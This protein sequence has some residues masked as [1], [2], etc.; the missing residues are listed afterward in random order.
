[1][2]KRNICFSAAHPLVAAVN[3]SLIDTDT[4]SKY[5]P[6]NS[7]EEVLQ[8]VR[9]LNTQGEITILNG[10]QRVLAAQQAFTAIASQKE[11]LQ[12]H[13][14]VLQ[15]WLGGM[16]VPT[17]Q[18][19]RAK[20]DQATSDLGHM[21]QTLKNIELWPVYFYDEGKLRLI[22]QEV[23]DFPGGQND[24]EVLLRFLSENPQEPSQPKIPDERLADILFRNLYN[25][26]PV[27]SWSHLIS[28]NRILQNT[29]YRPRLWDMVVAVMQVSPLLLGTNVTSGSVL[30]THASNHCLGALA[31]ITTLVMKRTMKTFSSC[32]VPGNF[33]QKW[34]R[35]LTASEEAHTM[36]QRAWASHR[37]V[38][39]RTPQ[40]QFPEYEDYQKGLEQLLKELSHAKKAL[41][42]EARQF[43]AL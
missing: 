24:P 40:P 30:Y 14:C 42:T 3:K 19:T 33:L 28:D 37:A 34:Q 13:I 17:E 23:Q 36:E 26:Q 21:E 10:R 31:S 25:R 2:M 11:R 39:K 8:R 27:K 41:S 43:E 7:G 35:L 29:C 32:P 16:T 20:L 5:E 22:P 9:F 4:L 38:W 12:A 18:R 6:A 1:M 15:E